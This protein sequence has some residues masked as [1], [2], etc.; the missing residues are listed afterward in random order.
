MCC[1]AVQT[2]C[3]A[4]TFCCFG[5]LQTYCDVDAVSQCV[6]AYRRRV[7]QM[8]C[9]AVCCSVLQYV[10]AYR[11]KALQMRCVAVCGSSHSYYVAD[12]AC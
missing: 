6:A 3:N 10:A 12:A 4:N 2:K 11:H 8:Q 7:L 5:E 9:V 1:S